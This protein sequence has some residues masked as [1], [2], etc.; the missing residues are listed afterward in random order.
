M[1]SFIL[2]KNPTFHGHIKHIEINYH[3]VWNKIEIGFTRLV[4]CNVENMV[5]NLLTKIFSTNKD[6]HLWCL[7]GMIKCVTYSSLNG[8]ARCQPLIKLFL[9]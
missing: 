3:L 6:E 1:H 5:V 2:L 9:L 7:I 4:Y 8:S